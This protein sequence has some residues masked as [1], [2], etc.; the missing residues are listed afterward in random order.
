MNQVSNWT[1]WNSGFA[2]WERKWNEE[3]HWHRT[4]WKPRRRTTE[5]LNWQS[6]AHRTRYNKKKGRR[7]RGRHRRRIGQWWAEWVEVR[8]SHLNYPSEEERHSLWLIN[9]HQ[10]VKLIR[11]GQKMINKRRR[12]QTGAHQ[13]VIPEEAQCDN[14]ICNGQISFSPQK[15]E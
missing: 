2:T 13:V 14:L 15:L 11:K 4:G 7:W 9:H 8:P 12:I 1:S 10:H 5:S 3:M 6:C